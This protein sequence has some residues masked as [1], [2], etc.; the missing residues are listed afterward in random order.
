MQK[1]IKFMNYL[2]IL[3]FVLFTEVRTDNSIDLECVSVPDRTFV[4][5]PLSCRDY[6]LCS[7]NKIKSKGSCPEPLLFNDLTQSCDP[8]QVVNC[9]SCKTDMG[10]Q[11]FIDARNCSNFYKCVDNVRKHYRCPENMYFDYGSSSCLD[12]SFVT[13]ETEVSNF[14]PLGN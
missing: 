12:K 9:N 11:Y 2:L 14:Y 6:F 7:P 13:C 8:P 10:L 1:K 3:S 4:R 5:N